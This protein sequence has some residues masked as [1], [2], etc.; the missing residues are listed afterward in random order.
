MADTVVKPKDDAPKADKGNK[1]DGILNAILDHVTRHG[2]EA[3][4]A[5]RAKVFDLSGG[6]VGSAAKGTID[7]DADA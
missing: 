6:K 5:L 4:D 2:S 3:D 7:E 1:S